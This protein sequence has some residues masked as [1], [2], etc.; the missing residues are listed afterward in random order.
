MTVI[1]LAQK[2]L[3]V[4]NQYFHTYRLHYYMSACYIIAYWLESLLNMNIWYKLY[5]HFHSVNKF[6]SSELFFPLFSNVVFDY[7]ILGRFLDCVLFLI[8]IKFHCDKEHELCVFLLARILF[9]FFPF[10]F[11]VPG[12]RPRASRVRGK[13]STIELCRSPPPPF[14]AEFLLSCFSRPALDLFPRLVFNCGLLASTWAIGLYHQTCLT[15]V[16]LNSLMLI[17]PN[18]L[19][20]THFKNYFSL[21]CV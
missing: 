3:F 15:S 2:L 21:L 18:S 6:S 7:Q 14:E 20:L 13:S 1:C 17:L 16:L 8:V 11:F 5:C 12:I 19:N 9:S 10:F 4:L